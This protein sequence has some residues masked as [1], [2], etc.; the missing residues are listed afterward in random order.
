MAHDRIW[1]E[2]NSAGRTVRCDS[3]LRHGQQFMNSQG[4]KI[5]YVR[6]HHAHAGVFIFAREDGREVVHAGCAHL[7][8]L[9]D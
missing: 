4:W 2:A 8:P 5:A 6:P 7:L 1:S 3:R 9:E